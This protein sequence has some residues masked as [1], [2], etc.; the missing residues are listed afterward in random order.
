MFKTLQTIYFLFA[1]HA[2]VF[3]IAQQFSN[4]DVIADIVHSKQPFSD[5]YSKI[6]IP[7]RLL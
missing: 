4:W 6:P 3:A 7:V 2:K 1:L 5:E